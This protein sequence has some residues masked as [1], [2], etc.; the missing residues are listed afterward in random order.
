MELM[1]PLAAV[2]ADDHSHRER[3]P[4]PRADAASRDR[5][6]CARGIGID[7]VGEIYGIAALQRF[8]VERRTR[9]H[10]IGDV[11]D[12]DRQQI[13]AG[14]GGVRVRPCGRRRRDPWR[15][16]DRS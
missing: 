7:A 5:L 11:G 15:R 13:A 14:V 10:V 2:R 16:R 1:T 4:V 3:R 6:R 8:L 9:P 12:G